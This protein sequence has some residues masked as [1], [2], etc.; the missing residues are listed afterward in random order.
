M[1]DT[2]P[3]CMYPLCCVPTG[4]HELGTY[5]Y[6]FSGSSAVILARPRGGGGS[7]NVAENA[8]C[9]PTPWSKPWRTNLPVLTQERYTDSCS[10]RRHTHTPPF[11]HHA[12]VSQKVV[13]P[14]HV[15]LCMVRCFSLKPNQT[16]SAVFLLAVG[17][18]IQWGQNFLS[19]SCCRKIPPC[20][21]SPPCKH[22]CG[23]CDLYPSIALRCIFCSPRA[24]T[25]AAAACTYRWIKFQLTTHAL[26]CVDRA[27]GI[28]K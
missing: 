22:A 1:G 7:G 9:A 5:S 24:A 16:T 15:V 26:R 4:H 28:D 12:C 25:A 10:M 13:T 19:W 27:G 2:V 21:R 11:V 3:Q 18:T 8:A 17:S 20:F 23:D 6:L 14:S